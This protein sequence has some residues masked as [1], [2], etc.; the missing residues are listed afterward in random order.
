MKNSHVFHH[1]S[2]S[3]DDLFGSEDV[4]KIDS[5]FSS[6]PRSSNFKTLLS[7]EKIDFEFFQKSVAGLQDQ[8]E[9]L[10]SSLKESRR[11]IE[12]LAAEK[13]HYKEF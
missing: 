3:L 6:S 5:S 13:D 8:C 4:K 10:M 7:G 2:L 1:Q 11:T 12:A 9:R